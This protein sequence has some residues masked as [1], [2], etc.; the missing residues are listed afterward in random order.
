MSS[1]AHIHMK[2]IVDQ[3]RNADTTA[4]QCITLLRQFATTVIHEAMST[5]PVPVQ[6]APKAKTAKVPRDENAPRAENRYAKFRSE[7]SKMGLNTAAIKALWDESKKDDTWLATWDEFVAS[8]AE[9]ST[10]EENASLAIAKYSHL[11]TEANKLSLA[12]RRTY[13]KKISASEEKNP[14]NTHIRFADPDAEVAEEKVDVKV[15]K[16]APEHDF[17]WVTLKHLT[18]EQMVARE[19]FKRAEKKL[20]GGSDAWTELQTDYKAFITAIQLDRIMNK[21]K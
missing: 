16:P 15:K 17:G 11:L 12:P 21:K 18:P 14:V 19:T 5:Q 4:E 2:N 13:T 3:I 1:P 9:P 7:I 20:T 10:P 6:P 8:C